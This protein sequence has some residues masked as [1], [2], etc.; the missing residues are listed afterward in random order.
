MQIGEYVLAKLKDKQF[1]INGWIIA[2]K[3]LKI[4]AKDGTLIKCDKIISYNQIAPKKIPKE[5]IQYLEV[6]LNHII[7]A[8][9]LTEEWIDNQE[10][11]ETH[12]CMAAL[13]DI[14][15]HAYS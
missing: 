7:G 8:C 10:M 11:P 14:R 6:K 3:P 5:Y 12:I 2:I 13:K 4:I 9:K 1:I 15:R